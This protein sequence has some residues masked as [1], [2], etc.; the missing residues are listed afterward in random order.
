MIIDPDSGSHCEFLSKKRM[1]KTITALKNI[2]IPLCKEHEFVRQNLSSPALETYQTASKKLHPITLPDIK[3]LFKT[4]EVNSSQWGKVLYLPPLEKDDYFVP[5]LSLKC[6]LYETPSIAQFRVM[7]I[8][9]EENQT[10]DEF[11][12][13]GF[14]M[15]TPSSMYQDSCPNDNNGIHDF[16]HAQLVRKL[17]S[18]LKNKLQITCPNWIPDSQPSFPLPADCPVTLL[19]CLIVTLYG[20][21]YC[22]KFLEEHKS[23]IPDIK[24]YRKK[25]K[26]WINRK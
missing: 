13:I 22:G 20:K 7:L 2:L 17:D 1:K 6:K 19:L 26:K 5:I 8:C 4:G 3:N 21:N 10:T 23:N 16:Y 15:E 24:S 9:L 12:G 18:K 14:R 11:Y 25:L